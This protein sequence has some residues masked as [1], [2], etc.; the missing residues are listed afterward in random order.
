MNLLWFVLA[1]VGTIVLCRVVAPFGVSAVAVVATLLLL[2][3]AL[4]VPAG[5]GVSKVLTS[6]F[7][8]VLV[9]ALVGVLRA[10]LRGRGH[11]DMDE[12]AEGTDDEGT[13]EPSPVDA[14]EGDEADA[15]EDASDAEPADDD[16][17]KES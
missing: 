16:D 6:M 13:D 9:A 2:L 12:A 7:V 3:L 14:D 8:G 11:V 4:M 1:V 5:V 17:R 10:F 15:P